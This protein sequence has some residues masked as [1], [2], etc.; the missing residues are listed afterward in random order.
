MI[1]HSMTKLATLVFI[2]TAALSSA[3]AFAKDTQIL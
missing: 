1:K 2:T 3:N